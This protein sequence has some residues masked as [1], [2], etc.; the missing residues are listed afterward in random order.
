M[1][2]RLQIR[3]GMARYNGR[4]DDYRNVAGGYPQDN[5]VTWLNV[6][7]DWWKPHSPLRDGSSRVI[8]QRATRQRCQ[9]PLEH[10]HS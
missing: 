7:S 2:A 9:R 6:I 10:T 8:A 3:R 1:T 5:G 4:D